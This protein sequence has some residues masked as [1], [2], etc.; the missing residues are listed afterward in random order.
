MNPTAIVNDN[1][2]PDAPNAFT[3]WAGYF[4]EYAPVYERSAFGPQ[5]L[6]YV[7]NREVDAVTD[8]L[9][10]CRPGR[11]LDAGAGTGRVARALTKRGWSI[12]ALDVS[13]EMLER[14]AAELPGCETV[15]GALGTELP[16][17]DATFDAVVS[18]RVLK[19]VDDIDVAIDELARV[20][21]PGGVTV[22]E[23][24]NGRSLARFGYRGS[25]IRF[26]TLH[27]AESMLREAGINVTARIAGTRLPYPIWRAARGAGAARLAA[28]VDRA[29][30]ACLGGRRKTTGARS[31]ILVGQRA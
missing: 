29:V 19:Y 31:I 2:T 11:V 14:L 26:V 9:A 18:M 17:A 5:G 10:A 25:P 15:S 30:G 4:D 1:A 23:F 3:G 8:A 24:A 6:A 28:F 13:T 21:R 27:E 7:G 16:F 20:L 22:L 12:T